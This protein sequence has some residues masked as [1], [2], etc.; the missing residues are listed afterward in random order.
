MN[1]FISKQKTIEKCE[2]DKFEDIRPI[3]DGIDDLFFV[4]DKNRVVTEVNKS[5]CKFFNKQPEELLGKHCFEIVH[6]TSSPWPDCPATK[7]YETKQSLTKEI[8]D[9]NCGV[10]LLITTSP[11]LDEQNELTHVIHVAK[12][13]TAIKQTE[14]EL[15][16]A[17]NLFDAI[18]DSILV[19]DM[20]GKILFF[21]E[22][23]Y[24]TRGYTRD[25]FQKLHIQDLEKPDT[26]RFFWNSN[27]TNDRQ[28]RGYIRIGQFAQGQKSLAYR[29]TCPNNRVRRQKTGFKCDPGY[30]GTQE[31]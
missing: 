7:T 3:I 14:M 15:H 18:S 8:I 13:M 11:L 31:S 26:P 24:K 25:E 21:N 5:T 2:N 9:P 4:M 1:T 22:A 30:F 27:E 28:W 12:D 17:A 23:A 10:P 16:I 19:H 20:D 29:S 6:G